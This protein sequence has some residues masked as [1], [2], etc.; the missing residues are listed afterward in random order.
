MSRADVDKMQKALIEMESSDE[1]KKI[2]AKIGV[3]GWVP[4]K[5]QEYVEMLSWL[6]V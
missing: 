1:G 3:K 6:G 5:A 2:L 4:G